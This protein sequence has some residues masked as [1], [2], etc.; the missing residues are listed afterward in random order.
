MRRDNINYLAAGLFVLISFGVV[1]TLLYKLTGRVGDAEAYHAYFN[2]IAGLNDG[3]RVTY[4]GY[5]I[6]Y[7]AG[8]QP[9]QAA[10]GT[11][12]RVN[13]LLKQG[14]RMPVDSVASIYASGLLSETVINIE[15]GS[16]REMLSPGAQ[17]QSKQGG[18]LFASLDVLAK[19]IGGLTQTSIRPLLHNLNQYVS[20][21]GGELGARVPRILADI[22]VI[23][24][25]LNTGVGRLNAVL[26]ARTEHGVR[27]IVEDVEITARNFRTLSS[28]LQASQTQL[29]AL[30][31]DAR[32][33]VVDNRDDVRASVLALRGVLEGLAGE[34]DG[35][36]FELEGA[37]R[38]MN[39]FSREIR[40]SPGLLLNGRQPLKEAR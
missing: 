39:E 22:E 20:Q 26:D 40:T 15:E 14:W 1:L 35:I 4:E 28:S 31:T 38:N 24:A 36:L 33:L 2:N 13:L 34:I 32:G 25:N 27:S 9:E 12:Y 7:V 23:V 5:Q 18:N 6:G 16:A 3:T 10:E 19:D 21:L 17:L 11:R 30:V 37:S 29:D 8:I